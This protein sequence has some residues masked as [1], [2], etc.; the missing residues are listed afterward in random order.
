MLALGRADELETDVDER[1]VVRKSGQL[2]ARGHG[3][4]IG[5]ISS[6]PG[7]Q[8]PLSFFK[9]STSPVP[10]SSPS[11][12]MT[13]P[14]ATFWPQILTFEKP[15]DKSAVSLYVLTSWAWNGFSRPCSIE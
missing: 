6:T 7:V 10:P 1:R 11:G 4:E 2:G 8:P 3:E 12:E 14:T 9:V 13:E 15:T 5:R